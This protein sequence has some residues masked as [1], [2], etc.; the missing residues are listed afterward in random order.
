M[1]NMNM[2]HEFGLLQEVFPSQDPSAKDI[3]NLDV[4]VTFL[5]GSSHSHIP[6]SRW[7]ICDWK[8]KVATIKRVRVSE[9]NTLYYA[10]RGGVTKILHLDEFCLIQ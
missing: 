2:L 4:L 1:T 6:S 10:S 8:G 5:C 7:C 3:I 9:T